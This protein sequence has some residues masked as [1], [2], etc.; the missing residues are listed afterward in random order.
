MLAYAEACLAPLGDRADLPTLGA[1]TCLGAAFGRSM[2][3]VSA[4]LL[5]GA[6][7]VGTPLQEL[8]R[9][10]LPASLTGASAAVAT[11][12]LLG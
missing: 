2:P 5:C 11:A 9:R 8:I 7:Y 6:G 1:L 10:L 3:P 12:L 4:V